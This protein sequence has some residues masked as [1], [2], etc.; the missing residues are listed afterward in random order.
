MV[1]LSN[2]L[3]IVMNSKRIALLSVLVA[4]SI[5]IQLLPRP[6][7]NIE[8]TSFLAFVTGMVFGAV[9]G[10]MLGALVMFVNGFL[11]S[12]GFA[13]VALPFQIAGMVLIGTVGG[14]YARITKGKRP[15]RALIMEA[16]TLGALL[17]L[18]Y[19]VVTNVGTA[20]WMSSSQLPFLQAFAVALISGSVF[21]V[22]H[23]GWNLFLFGTLTTPLVNAMNRVLAWR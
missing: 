22:I 11:S 5:G 12:Y 15:T 7:W 4:L 1:G 6:P 3:L 16:A 21:S 20:L 13:G 2:Q 10:A 14:L 17:T 18:V 8:F 9:F 23:I 19:D